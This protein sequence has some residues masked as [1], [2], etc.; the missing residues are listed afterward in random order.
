M[1]GDSARAAASLDAGSRMRLTRR[2]R[3]RSRQRS[4]AG[5]E[6]TVEADVAR[7][8]ERSGDVAVRQAADDGEGVTLGGND[9][10][11]FED[12]AQT[13]DV[14]CGPVGQIAQCALTHLAAFAV[15]LAQQDRR[16]RV[17]IRNSFDVHGEACAHPAGSVQVSN[18][19]LHGYDLDGLSRYRESFQQLHRKGSR[20]LGL[21][22]R[23]EMPRR[24][25]PT[26][27]PLTTIA[28]IAI[29][30]QVEWTSQT[31]V[32]HRGQQTKRLRLLESMNYNSRV[33]KNVGAGLII[34]TQRWLAT[35]FK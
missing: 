20:K 4:S 7:G 8:A 16:R 24:R 12:A 25:R 27:A 11:A 2:A 33:V 1:A 23:P 10:A 3:T 15:A 32:Q 18:M 19:I 22:R 14:S 29:V 5:A 28:G 6:D 26:R 13:F 21:G 34:F 30:S 35:A 9:R 31:P 17:P